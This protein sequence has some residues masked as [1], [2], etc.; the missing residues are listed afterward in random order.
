VAR[1]NHVHDNTTGIG[2][3]HPSAAAAAAQPLERNGFWEIVDNYVHDNNAPNS[4][5]PGSMSAACPGG[6]ILVPGSTT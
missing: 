2:L 3:Y 6:G 5:P 4:A 1:K